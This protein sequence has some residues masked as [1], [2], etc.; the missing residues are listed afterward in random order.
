MLSI[1]AGNPSPWT[2]PEGNNTYL[3]TG[4]VP[5]LVDAG[6]GEPAHVAAVADALGGAPLAQLLITHSHPDHARGVPALAARWPAV[7]VRNFA[8]DAC[9]DGESIR[10]GDTTLVALHTPGHAADHFCFLDD[11]TRD[12]Y[13]GDLA[14]S[15]GTIVIPASAGGNLAQYLASLR[16][17]RD[18]QPRRLLPGHGP[19]VDDPATLIEEYLRHRAEREAQVIELLRSGETTVDAIVQGIYTRLHPSVV[20]AAAD[21]VLAHLVKLREE[22]KAVEQDGEWR[23]T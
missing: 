23:A 16:R 14:R 2:G 13:C 20:R 17:V 19:I 3:L 9:R 21:S 10:A 12:V 4:A 18:L 7:V 15:G 11:T 1:P 5:T 8:P 6:V 22:G